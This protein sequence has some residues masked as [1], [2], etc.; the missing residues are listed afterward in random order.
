MSHS[1]T[2]GKSINRSSSISFAQ[3]AEKRLTRRHLLRGAAALAAS[4]T[5]P[6]QLT[7]C[8]T[9]GL[10]RSG[11]LG[12]A[13]VPLSMADTVRVPPGYAATPLLK[14]GD[15]IGQTGHT[16]GSPTFKADAS[17]TADEQAL[18]A[19]MHHAFDQPVLKALMEIAHQP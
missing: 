1:Y 16:S 4:A 7:A 3:I 14:W 5:L 17:N 18:Q 11:T 8:A 12:F 13:S 10:K 2:D 19:G 6:L 9:A 15:P